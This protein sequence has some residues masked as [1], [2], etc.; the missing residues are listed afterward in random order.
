ML[1]GKAL[2][3]AIMM[4]TAA[5]LVV[6]DDGRA[7][8]GDVTSDVTDMFTEEKSAADPKRDEV[9]DDAV[10]KTNGKDL[11][12]DRKELASKDTEEEKSCYYLEEIK[13]EMMD[14]KEGWDKEGKDDWDK[15]NAWSEEF[16]V[17]LE[18]CEAGEEESC[19]ELEALR[20]K[21]AEDRK[22][23]S[24][25]ERERD[26]EEESEEQ[27]NDGSRSGDD[28]C[29]SPDCESD[30]ESEEESNELTSLIGMDRQDALDLLEESGVTYRYCDLDDDDGC[31]MT[32]DYVIGRHTL[33]IEDGIVISHE[34]EEELAEDNK[35]DE[36]DEEFIAEM[37]ELKE[38]CGEG[39]EESCEE[40]REM[41]AE[42][43]ANRKDDIQLVIGED[44][45][46]YYED[47]KDK[48]WDKEE[49]DWDEACLTMEEWEEVFEKDRKEKDSRHKEDHKKMNMEY[50]M[51]AL[52]EMDEAEISEIKQITNTSDEEWDEMVVKMETKNMTKED[53]KTVMEKMKLVFE[54]E[55]KE[56]REEMEA[57]RAQMKEFDD[58]C[59]AGNETACEELSAMMVEIEENFVE[60]REERENKE[61]C[62]EHD[63]ESE[64]DESEE[65]ESEE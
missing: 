37:E 43:M 25:E 27:E 14:G 24:N 22:E 52:E 63:E 16:E 46:V 60:D 41:I 49:K 50:F 6:T 32:D 42:L 3:V 29:N 47:R 7:I 40:L 23:E 19:E 64:E 38:A 59:E 44:G 15:E 4:L 12:L 18:S 28:G 10:D 2:V 45:V 57:F 17:L 20:E 34:V 13:E 1:E 53:W 30:E 65:D 55:M 9:L 33:E 48:D 54:H 31:A 8:V 5:P 21:L 35:K 26:D 61:G 58:A 11:E 62:E 51:Y 36:F 56:E 39:N